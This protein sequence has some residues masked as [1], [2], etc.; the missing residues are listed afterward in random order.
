[1]KKAVKAAC[2]DLDAKLHTKYPELTEAEIKQLVVHE[3]WLATLATAVQTEVERVSQTLTYR[4]RQLAERYAEPLPE[5]AAEVKQ[6]AAKVDGH[7][8]RMGVTFGAS[9]DRVIPSAR[10]AE[11]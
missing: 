1:V 8:K 2:E 7:L 10:V 11:Q 9:D 3:K 4:I 5:L 6:L